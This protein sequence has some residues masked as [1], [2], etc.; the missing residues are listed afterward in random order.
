VNF[1]TQTD[2][3]YLS[4]APPLPGTHSIV[5]IEVDVKVGID[6]PDLQAA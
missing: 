5:V 4:T 2:G 3:S 1:I 6:M